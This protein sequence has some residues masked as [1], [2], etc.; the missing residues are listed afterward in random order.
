MSYL[1]TDVVK[2]TFCQNPCWLRYVLISNYQGI[3]SHSEALVIKTLKDRNRVPYIITVYV[4][5]Q[6]ECF[7][8]GVVGVSLSFKANCSSRR[9]RFSLGVM[10]C[11]FSHIELATCSI[12]GG[13]A[14]MNFVG[15]AKARLSFLTNQVHYAIAH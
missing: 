14:C 8:P 2:S 10:S 12:N 5:P 13:I 3:V 4:C 6:T 1:A 9:R 15:V 7:L 11:V